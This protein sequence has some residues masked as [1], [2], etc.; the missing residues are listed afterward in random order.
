MRLSI[1]GEQ[2]VLLTLEDGPLDISID[3]DA[4]HAGFGPLQMLATSLATCTG[5]VLASYAQTAKL[6]IDGAQIAVE[7]DYDQQ[8]YRVGAFRM[9]ILWPEAVPEP[10]RR[11]L[12]RAAEHCTVHTTLLHPPTIAT[13]LEFRPA[14]GEE[15]ADA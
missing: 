12:L 9:A 7:W 3:T 13:T 5:S 6:E 14:A 1:T 2:S 10:R 4:P 8:P 11:A 15:A